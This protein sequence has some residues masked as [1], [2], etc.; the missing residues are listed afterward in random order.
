[1]SRVSDTPVVLPEGERFFTKNTTETI[2][3][4]KNAAAVH[5]NIITDVVESRNW[6]PPSGETPEELDE[7]ARLDEDGAGE[8][9]EG[10]DGVVGDDEGEDGAGEDDEGE[11]GVVED[12]ANED[13]DEDGRIT[14]SQV[15]SF[16]LSVPPKQ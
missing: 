14:S 8:D 2:A 4:I 9:D 15:A 16:Q 12:D 7:I 13:G 3:M 10:E 11:D 6:F 5:E 1:M